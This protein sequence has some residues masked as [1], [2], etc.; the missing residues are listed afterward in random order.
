MSGFHAL[1]AGSPVVL[2]FRGKERSAG[3]RGA[4]KAR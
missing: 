2:R 4:G 3:R 1:L